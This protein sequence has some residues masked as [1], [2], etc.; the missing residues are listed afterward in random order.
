MTIVTDFKYFKPQDLE[1]AAALLSSQQNAAVLAGGTDLVGNLKAGLVSVGALIDIKGLATLRGIGFG[2]QTLKIGALVTFSELIESA[3]IR[4]HFPLIG[5][6]AKTVGSVAIRNRATMVGNICSA[7]P[8][9][10]SGPVLMVYEA[11]IN[12]RGPSGERTIP[13]ADWFKDSRKTALRPAEMATSVTITPPAGKHAGC[14]VKLGRYR[15]EDLAQASVAV[16]ALENR[17]YRL[18]FGSVGPVPSRAKSIEAL[19]AGHLPDAGLINAGQ[20]LIPR[21]IAPITDVRASKEYRLH[22]VKIMFERAIRAAAARL[23][24]RG[25]TYGTALI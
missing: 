5:E 10:D 16:L 18:S 25:P 12:V 4:E 19:L 9:M 20:E 7:V 13:A 14:F 15:G 24:G 2:D 22:M 6:M 21:E 11:G 8:C 17:L 3:I 23:S 1:E